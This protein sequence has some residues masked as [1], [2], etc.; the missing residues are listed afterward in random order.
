MVKN[1]YDVALMEITRL[2][3]LGDD[4]IARS[5]AADFAN[6]LFRNPGARAEWAQQYQ[7]KLDGRQVILGNDASGGAIE[8]LIFGNLAKL[9]QSQ[10]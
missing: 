5:V 7:E 6:F 3:R 2:N 1:T 9:D 8:R 10:D 4:A